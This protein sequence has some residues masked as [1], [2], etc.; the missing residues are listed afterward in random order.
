LDQ[1]FSQKTGF[2]FYV[3]V[4]RILLIFHSRRISHKM[5]FEIDTYFRGV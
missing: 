1:T 2:N 3:V 4:V 5:I